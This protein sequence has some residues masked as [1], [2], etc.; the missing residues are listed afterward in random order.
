MGKV[1]DTS[2]VICHT[3]HVTRHT[4]HVT[5]HRHH[6]CS[7]PSVWVRR[8]FGCCR[9]NSARDA[10]TRQ[11][12]LHLCCVIAGS[13][14]GYK[15]REFTFGQ[16]CIYVIRHTPYI[17]RHT[18]QL[19]CSALI[20]TT[21]KLSLGGG[22]GGGGCSEYHGIRLVKNTTHACLSQRIA[23]PLNLVR[24]GSLAEGGKRLHDEPLVG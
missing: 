12:S 8:C 20:K 14:R 23:C 2:R 7:V 9:F 6:K 17:T 24:G 1:F 13:S 3:L 18:S 10:V 5:R 4:S 21:I 19:H 22:G 15:Y 11:A 16:R